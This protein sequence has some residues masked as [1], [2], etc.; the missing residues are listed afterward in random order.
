MPPRISRAKSAVHTVVAGATVP[1]WKRRLEDP[2]PMSVFPGIGFD[3]LLSLLAFFSI[4]FYSFRS[5]C[6]DLIVCSFSGIL[7]FPNDYIIA[8]PI[9]HLNRT[10]IPDLMSHDGTADR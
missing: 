5:E 4:F 6:L 3:G 8:L 9:L 2:D 1:L 10:A 7:D